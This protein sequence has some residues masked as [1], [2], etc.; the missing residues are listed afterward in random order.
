MAD[1][2]KTRELVITRVFDAP[3]AKVWQA[4]TD[5]EVYKKWWGPKGFSAPVAEIDLQVGGK[6]FNCM[7][8]GP[9][10]GEF[11]GKRFYGV[12]SIRELAPMEKLVVTDSFAD[13]HGNVLEPAEVMPG[14]DDWPR[15]SLVTLTFEDEAEGKTKLT[16][17]H[18]PFPEG[19]MFANTNEG[20]NS[21]LD[22]LAEALQ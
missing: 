5:P 15:E 12:G 14:M 11:A 2:T 4:W 10:M 8:G 7:E 18:G 3:R 9:D 19:E 17:R 1:S 6:I 22:K 21:S 20:W 16:L 13:E